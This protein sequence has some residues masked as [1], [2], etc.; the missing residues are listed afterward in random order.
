MK[1]WPLSP[2]YKRSNWKTWL[3]GR[4][5]EALTSKFSNKKEILAKLTKMEQ[6]WIMFTLLWF[7]QKSSTIHLGDSLRK[8]TGKNEVSNTTWAKFHSLIVRKRQN[9]FQLAHTENFRQMFNGFLASTFDFYCT[10]ALQ[11]SWITVRLSE[12]RFLFAG[13][14]S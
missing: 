2:C 14:S 4:F 1:F 12:S 11:F 5:S 10:L 7:H 9:S 3:S 6:N 8:F 13:A